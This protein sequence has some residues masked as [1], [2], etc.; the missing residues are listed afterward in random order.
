MTH[1]TVVVGQI[2]DNKERA[3]LEEVTHLE[4]SCQENNLCERQQ[5]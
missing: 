2:S 5:D 4:N 1:D 3:Y